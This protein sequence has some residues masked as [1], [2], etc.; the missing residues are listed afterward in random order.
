MASETEAQDDL[1]GGRAIKPR[2]GPNSGANDGLPPKKSVTNK[3]ESESSSASA[4]GAVDRSSIEQQESQADEGTSSAADPA[5][6][7]LFNAKRD[8]P[9]RS[10]RDRLAKMSKRRI[11]GIVTAGVIGV[12]GIGGFGIIQGPL[13]IIHK[14][15]ALAGFLHNQDNATADRTKGLFRF[16]RSGNIGET[17]LTKLQSV[18]FKN[19]LKQFEADG[20]KITTDPK[21]GQIATYRVDTTINEKYHGLNHEETIKAMAADYKLDEGRIRIVNGSKTGGATYAITGLREDEVAIKN[22]MID[23]AAK[24][25]PKPKYKAVGSVLNAL[26][27]RAAKRFYDSAGLYHPIKRFRQTK[28]QNTSNFFTQ[29]EK[30]REAALTKPS[31]NAQSRAARIRS[32]LDDKGATSTAAAGL[33]VAT[34]ICLAKEVA[35]SVSEI[36]RENI[37]KPSMIAGVDAIAQGAQVTAMKDF[38]VEQL[39]A[40]VKTSIDKDGHSVFEGKA[41]QAA[42]GKTNPGGEDIDP[43]IKQ[44]YSPNSNATEIEKSL[45]AIGA[46]AICSPIGSAIGLAAGIFLVATGPGGWAAKGFSTVAGVATITAITQ[47]LPKL[48]AN[49]T[50]IGEIAGAQGGNVLAYGAR[51]F[52]NTMCRPSGCVAMTPAQSAALKKQREA[53]NL[54]EL[55]SKSFASRIFDVY[56]SRSLASR[57]IDNSPATPTRALNNMASSFAKPNTWTSGFSSIFF[58]KLQAASAEYDWG[59]PEFA[60]SQDELKSPLVENPYDNAE[61]AA[62]ILKKSPR[63]GEYIKTAKKCFGVDISQGGDGWD[64]IVATEIDANTREYQEED[65]VDSGNQDWLRIRFF[66]FDTRTMEAYAC[67]QGDEE[68]CI[69]INAESSSAAATVPSNGDLDANKSKFTDVLKLPSGAIGPPAIAY[70]HQCQ[71]ERWANKP[72]PYAAGG[73]NTICASGCGPSSLA[74]VVSTLGTEILNPDEMGQKAK[75]YHVSGGTDMNGAIK[76]VESYGLR[77]HKLSSSPANEIKDTLKAGGFVIMSANAASPFTQAGHFVV[78]RAMSSDGSKFYV[79]DPAD[80]NSSGQNRSFKEWPTSSIPGWTSTGLWAVEK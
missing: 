29:R 76:L 20:I 8:K 62:Q 54:A 35:G 25:L 68:A 64:V 24:N 66:I 42:E 56:D 51:E 77:Q 52:S 1:H 14:G 6:A 67:Y 34:T 79:A 48:L 27:N 70:Y 58:P 43:G 23:T 49:E 2:F 3:D 69:T 13:Q 60:F 31:P 11:A 80:D 45:D 61:K 5:E 50:P 28:V 72:Y 55:R 33:G 32:L 36:N 30:E 21:T 65:C 16:A 59:F 41:M 12:G 46:G 10:L 78:I 37:V 18:Q 39:G 22:N 44:A 63:S 19:I 71:D 47:F 26:G 57:M 38:S 75:D 74:M 40:I 9:K 73:S 53:D 17:R 15:E 7:S 4:N